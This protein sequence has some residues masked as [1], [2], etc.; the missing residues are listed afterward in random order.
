[1]GSEEEDSVSS[2]DPIDTASI[3]D[4]LTRLL[5]RLLW[6]PAGFVAI[7]GSSPILSMEFRV[8]LDPPLP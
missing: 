6:P 2:N 3:Y 1:M 8:L 5:C 4:S 7:L